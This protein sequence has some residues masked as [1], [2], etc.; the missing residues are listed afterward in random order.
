MLGVAAVAVVALAA[1]ACDGSGSGGSPSPD[2]SPGGATSV[3]TPGS[4]TSPAQAVGTYIITNGL[5][6]HKLDLNTLADCPLEDA[7]VTPEL[8]ETPSDE[9]TPSGTVQQVSRASLSQ[10]CL[11]LIDFLP[12]ESVTIFVDLPETGEVWTMKLEFDSDDSL[13]KVKDVDKVSG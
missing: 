6:G 11:T 10:F 7:P 8:G 9:P 12:E 2:A 3:I 4:G 1:V 13:W 5:D